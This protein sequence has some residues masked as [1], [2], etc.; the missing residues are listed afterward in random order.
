MVNTIK[1]EYFQPLTH[2]EM[3]VDAKK[4]VENKD[5]TPGKE[6]KSLQWNKMYK[7]LGSVA[8]TYE[9]GF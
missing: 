8:L 4:A 1:L 3:T 2:A 6:V 9:I 7:N 5:G